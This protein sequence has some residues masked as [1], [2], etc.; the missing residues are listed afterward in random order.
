MPLLGHYFYSEKETQNMNDK[1]T[2]NSGGS[3]SYYVTDIEHPWSADREP[4]TTEC[5][6]IIDALEMTP[7]EANI[8]KEVWRKAAARQ[9]KRKKGN[10]PLRSAEKIK[11][12]ADKILIKEERK[13]K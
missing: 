5:G 1:T 8:F 10:T 13:W 12:F 6:D 7:D 11:F 9:G 2:E 4:Y 3:C